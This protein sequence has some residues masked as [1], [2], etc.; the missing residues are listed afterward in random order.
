MR[1]ACVT[2]EVSCLLE[3][4]QYPL[5]WLYVNI[6]ASTTVSEIVWR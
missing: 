1:Y 3:M 2:R 5:W 6:P 4:F